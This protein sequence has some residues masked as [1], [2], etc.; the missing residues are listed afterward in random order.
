MIIVILCLSHSYILNTCVDPPHDQPVTSVTFQTQKPHTTKT[1]TLNHSSHG[2]DGVTNEVSNQIP[3]LVSTSLDGR[4]KTWVLVDWEGEKKGGVV[5]SWA[6]RSVGY[7]HGLSCLGSAFCEDG[8]LLALNFKKVVSD[9]YKFICID[10][11][12]CACC[13]KIVCW[14]THLFISNIRSAIIYLFCLPVCNG[15]G[16]SHM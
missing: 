3:L 12:I 7:Y 14:D 13:I 1:H 6:C 15:V 16:P 10:I 4:F 11:L 8:S 9:F 2:Y 5:P